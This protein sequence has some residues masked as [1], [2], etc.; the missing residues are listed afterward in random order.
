MSKRG[1]E[2][3]ESLA[4][5]IHDNRMFAERA[6]YCIANGAVPRPLTN[7]SDDNGHCPP[8]PAPSGHRTVVCPPAVGRKCCP[9]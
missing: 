7:S 8:D 3:A 4:E 2:A 1:C 5:A 6:F 9:G